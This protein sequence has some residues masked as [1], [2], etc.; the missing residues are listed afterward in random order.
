MKWK[1]ERIHIDAVLMYAERGI[2]SD[3]FQKYSFGVWHRTELV[4]VA[5]TT[6]ELSPEEKVAI[7]EWIGEH[8]LER[9]GPVRTVE[10][11]LVFGLEFEQVSESSRHKAGLILQ[12]VR[13]VEW[14]PEKR[15][16]SAANLSE[17][18]AMLRRSA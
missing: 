9:F 18:Q 3:E 4:P 13:I 12:G 16:A 2:A 14:K 1:P 15:P 5:K 10:P 11:G 17:L 8:M 6:L 7:D